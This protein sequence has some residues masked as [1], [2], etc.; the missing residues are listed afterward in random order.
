MLSSPK[1]QKDNN[2]NYDGAEKVSMGSRRQSALYRSLNTKQLCTVKRTQISLVQGGG[3]AVAGRVSPHSENSFQGSIFSDSN[4]K[5][6]KQEVIDC[7]HSDTPGKSPLFESS[8]ILKR[9]PE[10]SKIQE[11]DDTIETIDH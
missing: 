8:K 2:I 1:V 11:I 6:E 4:S 3:G 5:K 7:Y 9:N 10:L